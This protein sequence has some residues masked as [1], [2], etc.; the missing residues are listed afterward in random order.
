M[1]LQN[2]NEV[3]REA[4]SPKAASSVCDSTKH[5]GLITLCY[6]CFF[7]CLQNHEVFERGH[8]RTITVGIRFSDMSGIQIVKM[9]PIA[10]WYI[11]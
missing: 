1:T 9:C 2:V 11:S 4:L 8:Y 6:N 5:N 10:E 3:N 7:I